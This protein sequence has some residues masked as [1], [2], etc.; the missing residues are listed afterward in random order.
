LQIRD[1]QP[2]ANI[3]TVSK[4]TFENAITP[5]SWGNKKQKKQKNPSYTK[6]QRR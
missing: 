1:T 2:I 3:L 6:G 5:S 4:P